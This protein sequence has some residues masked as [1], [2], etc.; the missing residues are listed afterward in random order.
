MG[1][2]IVKNRCAFT[3]VEIFI[4]TIILGIL[5]CLS[6]FVYK[7]SGKNLIA[8]LFNPVNESVWEHLKLMFFPFLLWWIVMYIIKKQKCDISLNTWIESAAVSSVAAPL[9]V[10]LLYYSYT[11]VFGIESMFIDILLTFICYFIALS[12]A[13]HYLEYSAPN[14][15]T[16][17]VSV[18]LIII[19]FSAFIVFTINPPK[20]PIFSYNSNK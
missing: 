7:L 18:I 17:I 8:G 20:L 15:C 6:H 10:L 12:V 19:I 11:G 4:N 13:S 1:G 3:N 14:R 16:A 9:S 2:P 5:A